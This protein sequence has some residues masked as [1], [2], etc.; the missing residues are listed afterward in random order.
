MGVNYSIEKEAG[1]ARAA[2]VARAPSPAAFDCGSENLTFPIFAAM[3][4]FGL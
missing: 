3:Y 4:F 1:N 2:G